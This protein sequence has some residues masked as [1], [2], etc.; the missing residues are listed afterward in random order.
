[1]AGKL[2]RWAYLPFALFAVSKTLL[3]GFVALDGVP[4]PA[5]YVVRG[6]R[7]SYRYTAGGATLRLKRRP[8]VGV[9]T[10][11]RSRRLP[12]LHYVRQLLR[13]EWLMILAAVFVALLLRHFTT[14]P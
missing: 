9:L 5:P 13:R 4:E 12:R 10:V 2:S 6:G 3:L 8:P 7:L 11:V 1:M 14:L